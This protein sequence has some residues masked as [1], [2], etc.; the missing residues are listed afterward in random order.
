MFKDDEYVFSPEEITSPDEALRRFAVIEISK[1][2]MIQYEDE[3]LR[4]YPAE[5]YDL[6]RH[7]IR[8]LGNI[9]TEKSVDLLMDLLTR[10]EGLILGDTAAALGKLK[11]MQAVPD[12]L[13]LVT[14]SLEWVAQNAR[15]ALRRL[16]VKH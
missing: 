4:R 7:I 14:S 5:P 8:A 15:F 3:L 11:V 6:R 12:L 1:C 16:G 9:G 13:R 2:K 10:E